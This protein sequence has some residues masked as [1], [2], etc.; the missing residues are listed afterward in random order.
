MRYCLHCGTDVAGHRFCVSCGA[1]VRADDLTG[2]AA[3]SQAVSQAT[4]PSAPAVPAAPPSAVP[5]PGVRES[6]PAVPEPAPTPPADPTPEPRQPVA[7]QGVPPPPWASPT[8]GARTRR[9]AIAAVLLLLGAAAAGGFYLASR[10]HDGAG[11]TAATAAQHSP[12]PIASTSASPSAA[13]SPQ[14]PATASR[15]PTDSAPTDPAE[16]A[17]AAVPVGPVHDLAGQASVTV[18]GQAPDGRD[19]AN[20][21]VSYD[22]RN[23][24]DGDPT[25][26]WRIPGDAAGSVVSFQ[27]PS[28][29]VVTSVGLINGYAK[30]DPATG[31]DR[32]HQDRRI[33]HVTWIFPSGTQVTQELT[34][35]TRTV[36]VLELPSPETTGVVE[37]RIDRTWAPRRTAFDYT[38]VS[39]VEIDGRSPQVQ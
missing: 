17:T 11:T 36:Q 23:L 18:P 7:D 10:G 4:T 32:Y 6:T 3:P 1:R 14:A 33:A 29:S 12:S 20:R 8:P 26:C 31:A 24:V 19:S 39:S 35:R 25:T 13:Q 38:A 9:P 15:A 34:D 22:A 5:A 27:L 37:L 28:E 21:P 2:L 30:R 16:T